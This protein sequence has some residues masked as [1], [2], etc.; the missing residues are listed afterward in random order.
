[1]QARRKGLL[2]R[3]QHF[4]GLYVVLALLLLGLYSVPLLLLF[5]LLL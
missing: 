4:V 2:L 5:L 3:D 1:M